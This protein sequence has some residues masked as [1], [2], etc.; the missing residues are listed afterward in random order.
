MSLEALHRLSEFTGI[1]VQVIEAG[2]RHTS[3]RGSYLVVLD[4]GSEDVHSVIVFR[5]N[6]SSSRLAVETHSKC[7]L[8]V[9]KTHLQTLLVELLAVRVLRIVNLALAAKR[10]LSPVL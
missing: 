3:R 6:L 8:P 1:L 2:V 7:T 4:E 9:H 10:D 5:R